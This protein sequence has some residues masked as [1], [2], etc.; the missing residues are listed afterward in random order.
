MCTSHCVL[1]YLEFTQLS[2]RILRR[3]F[4]PQSFR[5]LGIYT[6]LK[7]NSDRTEFIE[8]FRV[9]GIYT[10]L[11]LSQRPALVDLGFRVLGIYTALKRRRTRRTQGRVLEYLEFTQLSNHI[12]EWMFLPKVL[13]YLEFTQLSNTTMTKA[14][15]GCSFRVLGIYTA[16]KQAPFVTLTELG[17]RVLGIYTA[18]KLDVH[19]ALRHLSFRVLGIYTALKPYPFQHSNVFMF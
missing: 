14:E 3:T 9:L 13:E 10:A 19:V 4:T 16:L 11:K 5:V 12:V 18:L 1:E 6:A 2:N 15:I 7:L 17:F 8:S